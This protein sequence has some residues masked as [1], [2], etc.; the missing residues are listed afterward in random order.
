MMAKIYSKTVTMNGSVHLDRTITVED[1]DSLSGYT[2]RVDD[3]ASRAMSIY[4]E[5]GDFP[6]I[7]QAVAN[8]ELQKNEGGNG[9]GND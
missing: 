5:P 3:P 2:L 1:D 7:A 8:N 9:Q 6:E 4:L